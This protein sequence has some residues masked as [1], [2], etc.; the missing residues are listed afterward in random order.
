MNIEASATS[1]AQTLE[2]LLANRYSCRGFL[3]EPVANSVI[4]RILAMAQRSPSWC[5]AQPWQVIVTKGEATERFR[6]ALH[7]YVTSAPAAPDIAFPREYRGAYLARRRAC[8]FALYDA[9]GVKRGDRA[10]L[11]GTDA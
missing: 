9:V 5:N 7:A 10:R 11:G 1:D 3:A 8:G 6:A 2:R 4:E